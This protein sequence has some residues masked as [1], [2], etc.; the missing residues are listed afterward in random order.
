[1]YKL[2]IVDD[3]REIREG[4][5]SIDWEA[6]GVQVAAYCRHGLEAYQYIAEQPVDIVLSDIRMPYMSGVELS[7]VL[8]REY[9]HV[10][11]I[12]LSGYS[13]FDYARQGMRNGVFDYL[14][15]PAS[16]ADLTQT[17][18]KLVGELNEVKQSSLRVSMLE[19]K[20]ALFVKLLKADFLK[21]LLGGVLPPEEFEDGCSEAEL[22]FESGYYTG[23]ILQLDELRTHPHYYGHK[24]FKLL[25]FALNNAL[26]ELW[27]GK[28]LG[29][30]MV[31]KETGSCY[32]VSFAPVDREQLLQ[33]KEDLYQFAGLLK[34][35]LSIGVGPVVQ[36]ARDIAASFQGA[37]KAAAQ[38]EEDEVRLYSAAD[39]QAAESSLTAP[40]KVEVEAGAAAVV[41]PVAAAVKS[42][43]MQSGKH[44]IDS[45]RKYIEANFERPITLREVSEHVH[46]THAYLSTLFREVT[47]QNYSHYVANLRIQKA[48]ELLGDVQY[49]VYEVATMVGYT[50]PAYFSEMFKK[51]AGKTPNE[52][53][54]SLS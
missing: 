31:D 1:M 21:Q 27:E 54:N 12:L 32:L 4:L 30:S 8:A 2:L 26:S 19:R 43:D 33:L 45:A 40:G 23:V 44:I 48:M 38:A 41:E 51:Y 25:Q 15:K 34:S 49:K 36:Q 53:R 10:K 37:A 29:Y 14:L 17:V 39:E 52:Y 7:E 13:D 11:M 5:K 50:D 24:E 28:K 42:V 18:G 20:Q 9:P 16:V 3:E 6:H 22:V 46:V 35:T 47:K